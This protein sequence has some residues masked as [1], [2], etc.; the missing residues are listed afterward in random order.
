MMPRREVA[1]SL[2]ELDA[3]SYS[4]PDSSRLVLDNISLS[5]EAGEYVAIVGANGSGKSSLLRLLD[6][7]RAPISGQ[8]RVQGLSTDAPGGRNAALA[9]VGLVFQSPVDQI[10]SSSVE[11]DVAFGPENLG[12]GRAEISARVEQ[13]LA[14]VGLSNERLRSTRFL[15]SGQQQRLAVAGALAMDA[16]CLAFDE[17]TAMLDPEARETVLALMDGLA[18]A[19]RAVI[20]VT[21]DMSEASRASRVLVLDSGSLVFDGSPAHLFSAEGRRIPAVAALGLPDSAALALA[22]GLEVLPGEGARALAARLAPIL[23]QNSSSVPRPEARSQSQPGPEPVFVLEKASHSYL[24]GTSN[25]IEAL[26][27]IDLRVPAGARLALVGRTGSG[28]STALQLLD[29]LVSPTAGSVSAF[30]QELGAAGTELR[31]IR[32]RAPLAIQRPESALF[33]RYAGDDVAF[34]PR[35]QGLSGRKLVQRVS[36]AMEEAGLPYSEFRDRATRSLSGGEKRR[37]ALAG[38][39]AMEG[40][41]LLLDEPTSALDPATKLSILELVLGAGRAGTTVVMATHSM[42]EAARA[43]LVAVFDKGR[44]AALADPATIFYGSLDPVWGIGRPFA[45]ELA[46]ELERLGAGPGPGW[47]P[48]SLEEAA[49]GLRSAFGAAAASPAETAASATASPAAA[50]GPRGG[51]ELSA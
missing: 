6:G 24:H 47:R 5:I 17:A 8:V 11:E 20:H 16:A 31:S 35:N 40:E 46:L 51:E 26:R 9:A 21:H 4:Y 28:K 43:D 13:A 37:L 23:R 48:L 44:L 3:V 32:M 19:G 10:V 15:S 39:L 22:L 50:P 14:A 49:A 33:E 7:L 38:V 36:R 25:E 12:L 41:A 29:G 18:A 27:G 30:G 42:A 2:L 45:C 34:G 1:M